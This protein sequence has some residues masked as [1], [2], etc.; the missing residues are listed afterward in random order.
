M[1]T[2]SILAYTN[3]FLYIIGFPIFIGISI[4]TLLNGWFSN[5]EKVCK[6]IVK[7]IESK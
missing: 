3:P 6:S 7:D 2:K 1:K 5:T 4:A